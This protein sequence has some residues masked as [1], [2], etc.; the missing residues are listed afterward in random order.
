MCLPVVSVHTIYQRSLVSGPDD[1]SNPIVIR[2]CPPGTVFFLSSLLLLLLLLP[3]LS[4]APV[5]VDGLLF[6]AAR[7]HTCPGNRYNDVRKVKEIPK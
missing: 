2:L 4:C 7:S 5:Y 1:L 6:A 3:G